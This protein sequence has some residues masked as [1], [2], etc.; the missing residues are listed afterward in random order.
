[1]SAELLKECPWD[2]VFDDVL[3]VYMER[4]RVEYVL[5]EYDLAE[6]HLDYLLERIADPV[7]RA[8][9][10]ELKVTINNHLGR[11]LKVVRIVRESL[12]ELGLDVPSDEQ[13]LM[14]EV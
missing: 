7:K 4:A 10:F 12:A 14:Q 9:I 6:I 3:P 1:M 13:V 2:E 11:Y 8:K 5:G